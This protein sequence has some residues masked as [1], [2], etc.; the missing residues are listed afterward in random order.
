MEIEIIEAVDIFS[1]DPARIG[2]K[3]TL[4]TYTVNKTRTYMIVLPSEEATEELIM[5]EITSKEKE[6]AKLVG[7]KFTVE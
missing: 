3:D 7:R 5:R 2:K 4:V 1:T 6:R